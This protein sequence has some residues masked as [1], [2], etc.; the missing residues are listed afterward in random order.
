[1]QIFTEL[2]WDTGFPNGLSFKNNDAGGNYEWSTRGSRA[3]KP[4]PYIIKEP[5]MCADI[6]LRIERLGLEVDHIYILLR[7]PGPEAVALEFMR[8][9]SADPD[10]F[11]RGLNGDDLERVSKAVA[12]REIQVMNLVA[13]MDIPHTLVSYPRFAS[14]LKY[15][16]DKFSFLMNLHSTPYDRFVKVCDSIIDPEQVQAAYGGQ[17]EWNRA[18]QRAAGLVEEDK[19]IKA[20]GEFKL[21]ER[22]REKMREA[23]TFRGR[24]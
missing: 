13:E 5:Q 7:R 3:K 2:G 15:A 9:G 18:K 21:R 20:I 10:K 17:P 24:L 11:E 12:L 4:F 23:W 1:M 8:R 6:D 22:N 16:Y 19:A 14:D